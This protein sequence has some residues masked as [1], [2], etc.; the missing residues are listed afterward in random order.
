MT[1]TRQKSGDKPSG[2]SRRS[3]LKGVAIGGSSLILGKALAGQ[4]TEKKL[5]LALTP[6][7]L[8]NILFMESTKREL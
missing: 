8:A 4:S 1:A 7:Q 5:K 6:T 2:L 3:L